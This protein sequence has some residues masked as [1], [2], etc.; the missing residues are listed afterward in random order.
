MKR[1]ILRTLMILPF[2]GRFSNYFFRLL[3]VKLGIN[4]RISNKID[5]IGDYHNLV[6]GDNSEINYGVFLL[7]K[8]FIFLGKNSTLAYKA[9]ILTSSNPNSPYNELS[10]LYPKKIAP[11]KIGDNVWIGAGA[12][13]LPGVTIGDYSVV[14][15][16]AVVNRNVPSGVLVAGIPA[17]IIKKI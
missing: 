14:A 16:G 9:T 10:E 3:G 4:A 11:V 6:L 13:I 8:D 12:I 17:R 5:L 7:A 15:A 2:F 1:Y